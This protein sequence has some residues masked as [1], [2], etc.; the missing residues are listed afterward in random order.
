MHLKKLILDSLITLFGNSISRLAFIVMSIVTANTL[1][2]IDFQ[3]VTIMVSTINMLVSSFGF[4]AGITIVKSG[5][6]YR[7][8]ENKKKLRE[9]QYILSLVIK[10]PIFVFFISLPF[11]GLISSSLFNNNKFITI[12]FLVLSILAFFY[13]IIS[14]LL[15]SI[16]NFSAI[17][18][19]KVIYGLMFICTLFVI[20]YN[21]FNEYNVYIIITA[22]VLFYISG[23]FPPYKIYKNSS[24][25]IKPSRIKLK[26]GDTNYLVKITLPALF[27]NSVYAIAIWLQIIIV[28][29]LTKN[30]QMAAEV[31][32]G[33]IWFNAISYIPQ[34]VSTVILPKISGNSSA[35]ATLLKY[36]FFINLLSTLGMIIFV[37]IIKDYLGLIY[38]EQFKNMSALILFLSI[39]ALPNALCKVT[40]Q[41]FISE[42]KM[43]QSLVFNIIW[44][45]IYISLSYIFLKQGLGS[46]SIAYSLIISYSVL[47]LIQVLY[48]KVNHEK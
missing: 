47:L 37:I 18:K 1:Y 9:Y 16:E 45:L 48:I 28:I 13:T 39:A 3:N 41:Y 23:I 38:D 22:L 4:A 30:R 42:L 43:K 17:A 31:A 27:S 5:V 40:G 32:T 19:N 8:E 46:I 2:S 10:L 24:F 21:G 26:H 35:K 34:I 14:Y 6:E 29:Y 12:V 36:G 7:L 33:M 25:Y 11:I 20:N 15:I 44:A